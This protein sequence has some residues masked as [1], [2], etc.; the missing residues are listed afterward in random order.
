VR[1]YLAN[2]D[3]IE[4]KMHVTSRWAMVSLVG[5]AL[6]VAA[7]VTLEGRPREG[8][9]QTPAAPPAPAAPAGQAG[10]GLQSFPAQQRPPADPA[11]VE[12]G[13]Q[14]Y[15][16]ACRSCHGADLRGGDMGGPNLLRSDVML[17]DRSGETLRPVVRGSRATTGMPAIDL[18]DADI[19]AVAAYIHSVLATAQ[20]QG[21]PPRGEPV[22]LNVLVGDAAAG[23]AYFAAKCGACHSPAGDLQGIGTRVPDAMRLQNLWVGGGTAGAAAE[24]GDPPRR[25]DATVTVTP[26]AG[27]AVAGRLDRIDD[28][29]VTLILTGGTRRTFRRNGDIPRVE[30]NDPLAAHK[31]MLQTYTD[32]DMHNVTAYLVTLK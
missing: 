7:R 20:G 22:T 25:R 26:A 5:V 32:R 12:R 29:S 16:I 11:V 21:A 2:P 1:Y 28:F 19:T 3:S 27:P 17:N 18:P 13:K 24:P 15:G 10:R 6:L 4:V 30:I 23:Q 31:A 9:A 14:L 8:R